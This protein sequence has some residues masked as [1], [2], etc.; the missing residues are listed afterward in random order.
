MIN[1]TQLKMSKK[2]EKIEKKNLNMLEYQKALYEK[3]GQSFKEFENIFE[4]IDVNNQAT[5]LQAPVFETAKQEIYQH[6]CAPDSDFSEKPLPE[7]FA[8]ASLR[9]S[10]LNKE[11]C[12]IDPLVRECI[13]Y[14][15]QPGGLLETIR[16][17]QLSYDEQLPAIHKLYEDYY[18]P[19]QDDQK[20]REE[21]NEPRRDGS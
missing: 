8:W 5:K 15:A 19:L 2:T 12:T 14:V 21:E 4:D 7:Q 20:K 13:T 3:Y 9:E 16:N 11:P 18:L 1:H 17:P 6:L 10:M